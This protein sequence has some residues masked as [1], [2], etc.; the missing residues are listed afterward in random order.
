MI[1]RIASR[2]RQAGFTLVELLIVL[3]LVGIVGSICLIAFT[4]GSEALGRTD[5]D[6]QGQ[7]DL[8]IVTERLSRD[9]RGARGVSAGSGPTTLKIWIDF[10]ADY[11]QTADET[12]TWQLATNPG[13]PKHFNVQRMTGTG[14]NVTIGQALVSGIAFSYDTADPTKARVVTVT[15]TYD[16]IVGAYLGQKQTTF[17][18]RM[19][20]VQ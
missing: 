15:M 6:A 18:I 17:R 7:Q 4:S 11:V 16:A 3:V 10:N 2:R 20:N 13:D 14:Q 5:D 1:A 12:I 8:R 9:I 19:R